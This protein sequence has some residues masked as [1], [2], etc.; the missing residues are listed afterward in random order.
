M[1][2][3]NAE[4]W[5]AVKSKNLRFAHLPQLP[6]IICSSVVSIE[7]KLQWRVSAFTPNRIDMLANQPQSVISTE[8]SG[9]CASRPAANQIVNAK[10]RLCAPTCSNALIS[11]NRNPCPGRYGCTHFAI[12]HKLRNRPFTNI[13][14]HFVRS[15]R[16]FFDINFGI[17]DLMLLQEAFSSAAIAAP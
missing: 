3:P 17:G 14:D 9:T 6:Q 16:S 15:A 11:S 5:N 4:G 2:H 10:P 12:D 7:A 13:L 8:A 1:V